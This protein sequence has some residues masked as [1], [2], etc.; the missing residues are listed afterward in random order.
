M[1]LGISLA[2][3]PC[4]FGPIVFGGQDIAANLKTIRQLGYDG[5]DLFADRKTDEEIDR[6]AGLLETHGL[7]VA[8]YLAI[9]L[10]EMGCKL[11]DRDEGK[12]TEVVSEYKKQIL[13]GRKLRAKN[14]PIGLLRGGRENDEPEKT[15]MD[16]LARSVYDLLDCAED[17]GITLCIEPVNRY[18]IN[19]LNRLDEVLEF[20]E[21]YRF[22]P[23]KILPDTFHMNIEDAS[24]EKAILSA[25][26]KIGHVHI[27]DSNRLAPGFGHLNYPSII[28][29][30]KETGYDGYLT[31]EALPLPDPVECAKQNCTNAMAKSVYEKKE[32]VTNEFYGLTTPTWVEKGASLQTMRDEAFIKIIMGS[33]SIDTFD[34]FVEDFYRLGGEQATK[35]VNEWYA[36]ENK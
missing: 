8:M 9:Y 25:A 6:L 1:K 28:K 21:A 5:V 34:K 19:T 14:M 27:A 18:E 15:Y 30:L 7:E 16:R 32:Y 12:R 4:K 20:I 22:H 31:V 3:Y 23:L 26:G 35:E 2:A 36:E 24:I 33:A 11:A 17:A 13:V 29:S 10:A